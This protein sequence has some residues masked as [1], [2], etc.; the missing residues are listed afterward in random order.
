MPFEEKLPIVPFWKKAVGLGITWSP[1]LLV[2]AL[3]GY[4]IGF[5]EV[6]LG[7]LGMLGIVLGIFFFLLLIGLGR[8]LHLYGDFKHHDF[9]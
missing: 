3:L 5:M 1:L 4:R 8:S 2:V 6:A 9:W 7:I